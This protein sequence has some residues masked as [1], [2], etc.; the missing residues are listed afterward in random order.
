ML[1]GLAK[2]LAL[3]NTLGV[4]SRAMLIAKFGRSEDRLVFANP[5]FTRLTGYTA[6][7]AIGRGFGFLQAPETDGEVMAE[8]GEAIMA[9]RSIRREVLNRR[10]TGESF[11]N[12]LSIDPL[13]AQDGALIGYI[14]VCE[15]VTADHAFRQEMIGE[16]Q[17]FADI[18][19]RIP[20][21]VY[22]RVLKPDGSLEHPYFSPS[23]NHLLGLP[24]GEVVTS[25]A[26]LDHIHPD[27]RATFTDR[28]RQSAATLSMFRLEFRLVSAG[29][30][31]RWVR[32][33]AP[34]RRMPNGDVTWDGV[35]LDITAEKAAANEIAFLTLHDSLTGLSNR[36]RFEK[37]VSQAISACSEDLGIGL[38]AIDVHRLQDI[39]DALGHAAGD[40]AL[41]VIGQKLQTLA[42]SRSG[43]AARTSSDE[44]A[45]LLPRVSDASELKDFADS[46]T[47]SLTAPLPINAERLVIQTCTGA[48]LFPSLSDR[49]RHIV[50]D[51]PTELMKRADIA[52][53]AAKREGANTYRLYTA[54]TDDRLINEV[55]LRHSL[56]RAIDEVQF[57]LHYQPLVDLISGKIDAAE[58]LVRWDHPDLGIQRPDQFIPLAEETGLIAPLGAWVMAEAMKHRQKWT[59]DGLNAPNIA[60]N[61]S[62]IQLKRPDFMSVVERALADSGADPRGFEF[63]LTEG[64]AIETSRETR[65]VLHRL[66]DMGFCITIDDFGAGHST[67]KYLKEFPVD[68]IKIDKIFIR[69]LTVGS[70]EALIVRSMIGLA[71]SL[72]LKIVAEGVETA[73]QRRFL[74][75]EGCAIGQGYHF[76]PP[77]TE[78]DFAWLVA[79]DIKLPRSRAS[80]KSV[81]A[82]PF[83]K[84]AGDGRGGIMPR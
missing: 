27:D 20:G 3:D 53:R 16:R 35:A 81:G 64:I 30:A 50:A 84:A 1:K 9:G 68:K 42:E 31:V 21:Y 14:G 83:W 8:I 67:F 48:V 32:C 39:N 66:R 34:A 77:L 69:S 45:V 13:R 76:S 29:G 12:D 46:I 59:D 74:T 24:E 58:A 56:R 7:D 80:S 43:V 17:R 23:L 47:E 44:F 18:T 51:M 36:A 10:K 4:V 65:E 61:V 82:A 75:A 71:R 40:E 55:A 73:F 2:D 54:G 78:E 79:G 15:D 25:Q 41:R 28:V 37:A 72:G 70:N 52:L 57:V 62:G 11:W 38:F 22:R 6:G 19:S 33:D 26:F 63:E 60:I 5:A 49:T